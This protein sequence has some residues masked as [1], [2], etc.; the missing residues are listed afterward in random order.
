VLELLSRIERGDQYLLPTRAVRRNGPVRGNTLTQAMAYFCGRIE[1][2]D[3]A[4][5]TWRADP[6]TPHD[7]RRTVGTRLAEL[8]V[9]KEIRDR[10][11]N[12]IPA[13]VGAKHYNAHDFHPEK[14]AA[15]DRWAIA[16]SG[17]L[18]DKAASV[19]DFATVRGQGR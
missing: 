16:L 11:L 1:G 15:F 14:R 6:P 7:L 13:D 4:A 9:T 12:H 10:C 18:G 19:I 2:D 5:R 17:I 8:G 3:D